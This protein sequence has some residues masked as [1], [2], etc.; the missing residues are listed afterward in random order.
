MKI[1]RQIPKF[2][3]LPLELRNAYKTMVHTGSEADIIIV[4]KF[5]ENRVMS[6]YTLSVFLFIQHDRTQMYVNNKG[7][8]NSLRNMFLYYFECLTIG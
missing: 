7:K 4:N 3:Q 5:Q 2:I 1:T 8:G 6:P